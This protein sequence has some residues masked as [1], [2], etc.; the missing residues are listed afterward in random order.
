MPSAASIRRFGSVETNQYRDNR[1][2]EVNGQ[3]KHRA[4][5]RAKEII[6][7]ES[8]A[9]PDRLVVPV[10][11][12]KNPVNYQGIAPDNWAIGRNSWRSSRFR[13]SSTSLCPLMRRLDEL[14]G[15][16]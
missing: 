1:F 3:I 15:N 5:E 12:A 9:S 6:V 8:S 16:Y 11:T 2:E 10:T 4:H 14:F 7:K 13:S